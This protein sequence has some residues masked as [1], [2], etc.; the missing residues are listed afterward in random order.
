[1][2]SGSE[3]ADDDS[4]HW[5]RGVPGSSPTASVADWRADVSKAMDLSIAPSTR[6]A[7]QRA[8]REF[9]AFRHDRRYDQLWP[10]P[11]EHLLEFCALY[12]RRGLSAR[13]IRGKLAGLAFVAKSRGFADTTGDFRIRKTLEG[14]IREKGPARGD[15]RRPLKLTH[16]M[17]L[18]ELWGRL[19]RS[20]YE[21][22]LY[23]AAA[24]TL[25]FGAFRVSEVLAASRAD[26]SGQAFTTRDIK[27]GRS[28]VSLRLRRSKTD[29][30]GRGVTVQLSRA[31]NRRVC[32]VAALVAYW[33]HR[34]VEPGF[35]FC[36]ASGEPLTRYQF[37]AVT[38][39]ALARL[40]LDP[41]CYGTH[42]F[43][44]GAASLAAVE[45]FSRLDI[46]TVGRWRS[47]AFRTYI[48]P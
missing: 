43:R 25:F 28:S 27:L 39:K 6:R 19:C 38:S 8:G 4:S 14:W 41:R 18:Y 35:L 42:S 16:L 12:R 3:E 1:M 34:G 9:W 24:V 30:R 5:G 33:A 21:A 46:K 29:Q 11:V 10:A 37:W 23:H 22:S 2:V 40:G 15:S 26:S 48:R 20:A 47:G 31:A 45:G 17:G 7:Y 32:P 36:H 13:T 44:I